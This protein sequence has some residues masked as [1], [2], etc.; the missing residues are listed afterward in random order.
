MYKYL[1]VICIVSLLGLSFGVMGHVYSDYKMLD[2]CFNDIVW[3]GKEL[4]LMKYDTMWAYSFSSNQILW[5]TTTNLSDYGWPYS[6][7]YYDGYYY[8]L[9]ESQ[10]TYSILKTDENFAILDSYNVSISL[11]NDTCFESFTYNGSMF[12]FAYMC[13]S[14]NTTGIIILNAEMSKIVANYTFQ[15]PENYSGYE[16]Y[17]VSIDY[18]DGYIWAIDSGSILYLMLQNGTTYDILNVTEDISDVW[19]KRNITDIYVNSL[20]ASDTDL[21]VAV[22]ASEY[23]NGSYSDV[24]AIVQYSMDSIIPEELKQEEETRMEEI[25][26]Q[27]E[28]ATTGLAGGAV[29]AASAAVVAT[30][31]TAT[32]ASSVGAGVGVPYESIIDRIKRLFG[33]RKIKKLKDKEKTLEKPDFNFAI[34]FVALLGLTLA[35]IVYLIKVLSDVFVSIGVNVGFMLSVAG[36]L[37]SLSMLLL[38]AKKMINIKTFTK[39]IVVISLLASIYGIASNAFILLFYAPYLIVIEAIISAYLILLQVHNFVSVVKLGYSSPSQ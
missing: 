23:I 36:L 3:N 38:I 35:L 16:Y 1:S 32:V 8:F 5:N 18:S 11:P 25:P 19:G 22:S 33:L 7:D 29:G 26:K 27:R 14:S 34:G 39:I 15:R 30:T 9:V 24:V 6:I 2:I 31:V 13:Y 10:N 17:V 37:V 4:V 21:Y 28:I 20:T 12:M